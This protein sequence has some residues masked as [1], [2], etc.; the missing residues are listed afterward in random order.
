MTLGDSGAPVRLGA[1][2]I[3]SSSVADDS[4]GQDD[5]DVELLNELYRRLP[6]LQPT[7]SKVI[8]PQDKHWL[9][10]SFNIGLDL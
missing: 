4:S 6:H 7:V 2:L 10:L 3:G 1:S 9:T 5:S 8:F